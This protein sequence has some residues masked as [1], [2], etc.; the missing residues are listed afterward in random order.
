MGRERAAGDLPAV[1]G[2]REPGGWWP[3]TLAPGRSALLGASWQRSPPHPPRSDA[4]P[5]HSRPIDP[6]R[7]HHRLVPVAMPRIASSEVPGD[8]TMDRKAL[9]RSLAL[10]VA[11]AS[12]ALPC[13]AQ[14]PAQPAR[15][16]A[17][18]LG[19]GKWQVLSEGAVFIQRGTLAL[20]LTVGQIRQA[21]VGTAYIVDRLSDVPNSRQRDLSGC[22][23]RL[24]VD[25]NPARAIGIGAGSVTDGRV[26]LREMLA[27]NSL[28][29]EYCIWPNHRP[30]HSTFELKGFAQAWHAAGGREPKS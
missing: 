17:Q 25:S 10:F 6:E 26:L 19:F 5:A 12:L 14:K 8:C 18:Q 23:Q 1:A 16:A 27:G 21:P 29:A 28:T 22:P 9:P 7:Y 20:V 24:R 30:A 15:Q 2:L 11:V 3:L 13:A 4:A